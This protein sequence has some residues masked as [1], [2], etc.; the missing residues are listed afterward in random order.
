MGVIIGFINQQT[1]LGGPILYHIP[2]KIDPM[3]PAVAS[4][5]KWD[6]ALTTRGLEKSTVSDSGHGSIG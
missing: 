3:D 2:S 1:S 5:R 4:E 6:W